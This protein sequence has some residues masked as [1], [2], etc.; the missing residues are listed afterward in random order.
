MY[1]TILVL[2]MAFPQG[3]V[4][5]PQIQTTEDGLRY[6]STGVGYDSR[7]NLPGFSLRLVFATKNRAF[8]ADIDLEISPGPTG[9][10]TKIHSEGP[11]LEVDLAP[12]NYRVVAR[13]SKGQVLSK[14]L[15]IVKGR[16][17]H[18]VL[19]WNITDEEI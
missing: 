4:F 9:K 3:K 7:I 10:A 17:T 2:L 15:S 6:V 8:L 13:T 12:G 16:A 19:A 5:T 1:A 18:I 14:T 11:W